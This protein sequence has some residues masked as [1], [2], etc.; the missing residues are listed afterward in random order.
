M[1]NKINRTDLKPCPF[2]GGEAHLY[3]DGIDY[4]WIECYP[5]GAQTHRIFRRLPNAQ[6]VVVEKWNM[7]SRKSRRLK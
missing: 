4:V 2:C 6:E 7:R 5:C 3:D 1:S